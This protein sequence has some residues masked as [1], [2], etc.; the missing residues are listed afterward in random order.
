MTTSL[1]LL[2]DDSFQSLKDLQVEEDKNRSTALE[3]F[4][5]PQLK[6]WTTI[7]DSSTSLIRTIPS[8]KLLNRIQEFSISQISYQEVLR[9]V[10]RLPNLRTLVVQELKQPSSGTFLSQTIRLS[11]L[12]VLRIEQSATYGMNGLVSFLDAIACP[13]LQFLG[14]CVERYAVQTGT[15]GTK[16]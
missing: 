1:R 7:G 9:I 10:H 13:S 11:G 8:N 2:S 6:S 5:A 12:K 4:I 3:H 15:A 14:V 16:Y